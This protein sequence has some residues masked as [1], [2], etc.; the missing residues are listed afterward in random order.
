VLLGKQQKGVNMTNIE[1]SLTSAQTRHIATLAVLE[2]VTYLSSVTMKPSRGGGAA[3]FG[4]YHVAQSKGTGLNRKTLEKLVSLGHVA[5]KTERKASEGFDA[6]IIGS[7]CQTS[8][9]YRVK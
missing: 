9:I 7:T 1:T 2:A 4:S 5:R 6:G 3:E 8:H